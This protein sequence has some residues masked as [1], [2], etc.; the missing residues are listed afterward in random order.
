MENPAYNPQ[1]SSL[2]SVPPPA[3]APIPDQLYQQNPNINLS[4]NNSARQ[5]RNYDMLR[6]RSNVNNMQ[7]I[8]NS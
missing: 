6:G 3:P 4:N 7:N 2:F 8:H 1:A 5:M